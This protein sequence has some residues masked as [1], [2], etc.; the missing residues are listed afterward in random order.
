MTANN[1]S[2]QELTAQLLGEINKRFDERDIAQAEKFGKMLEEKLAADA[3][4]R[5]AYHVPGLENDSKEVKDFSFAKLF[6]GMLTKNF[7][8]CGLEVDL[9]KE[10]MATVGRDMSTVADPNGGFLVPLQVMESELVPL[11]QET[12]QIYAWGARRLPGLSGSPVEINKITGGTT[13]YWVGEN[14]T[15]TNSDMETGKMYLTPRACAALV[16][17]SNRLVKLSNPN[18]ES[19]VREQMVT[20]LGLAIESAAINGTGSS[21]QP[22][23]ILQATGI[24]TVTSFGAASGSGAYDKL[25]DVV[26][27]LRAAKALRGKLGWLLHPNVLREFAKMKDPTD[28]SQPKSRRVLSDGLEDKILGYP[29]YVTT[30]IPTNTLLFGNASDLIIGEWGTI[31]LRSSDVAGSAFEKMQT[32]VLAAMEVDVGV[33]QVASFCT[34]TGMS[35]AS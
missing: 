14:T 2:L 22:L 8:D 35:G 6:N 21:T 5:R 27:T 18:A 19:L 28:A 30:Q 1:A 15:V 23:G 26:F 4:K 10:A 24:G 17:L 32:K 13:A 20:D 12:V 25:Q 34:V 9:C 3:Q 33:R 31:A 29:Y 7:K 11:L 16:N